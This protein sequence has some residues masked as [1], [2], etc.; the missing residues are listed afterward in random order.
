MGSRGQ[1]RKASPRTL[2]KLVTNAELRT[3]GADRRLEEHRPDE[4]ARRLRN[5][6]P[7]RQE[8]WAS[9]ETTCQAL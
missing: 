9:H 6:F 2:T 1:T 4:I 7:D 8:M 3:E 5:V